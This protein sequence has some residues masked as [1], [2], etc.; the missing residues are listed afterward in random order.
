MT[1]VPLQWIFG[2]LW[3]DYMLH[4][5]VIVLCQP[6][7]QPAKCHTKRCLE[8]ELELEYGQPY[9]L[10]SGEPTCLLGFYC[11]Y[12]YVSLSVFD[13][14]SRSCLNDFIHLCWITSCR[15]VYC[16]FFLHTFCM[17][18][19]SINVGLCLATFDVVLLLILMRCPSCGS[20]LCS[21]I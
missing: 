13:N 5:C 11:V 8:L 20:C 1:Y 12:M 18:M 15:Y 3:I 6:V 19:V 4:Q 7:S 10:F 9:D 21:G 16:S 2:D 14:M 17:F